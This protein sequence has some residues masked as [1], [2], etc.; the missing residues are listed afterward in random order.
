MK[1]IPPAMV[2]LLQKAAS[3]FP[4]KKL[5]LTFWTIDHGPTIL[6]TFSALAPLILRAGLPVADI[7]HGYLLLAYLFDWEAQ[8]QFNGWGA[9]ENVSDEQFAA[10]VAGFTEV[11]LVAEAD[12][13]RTQMAAFRAYPDDLEHWFTAA[14]EGQHAFSGDLDR[15]EYLTQY[16]CD[17]ADELLYLK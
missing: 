11:G 1:Q 10:I 7:P 4:H 8:C 15:L 9:F 16:F 6:D 2:P 17:H 5:P 3:V 13:L 12:S 14:Q